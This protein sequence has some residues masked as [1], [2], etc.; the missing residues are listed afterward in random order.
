MSGERLTRRKLMM[1]I[2]ADFGF[3]DLRAAEYTAGRVGSILTG[4]LLE[5]RDTSRPDKKKSELLESLNQ[6]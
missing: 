2:A 4:R 1:D 3:S 6:Q 5:H